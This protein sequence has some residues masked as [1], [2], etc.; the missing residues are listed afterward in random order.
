MAT[1]D[2]IELVQSSS[3]TDIEIDQKVDK[4]EGPERNPHI[5]GP[6]MRDRGGVSGARMHIAA[7]NPPSCGHPY[8]K[9]ETAPQEKTNPKWTVALN[10]EGRALTLRTVYET[11]SS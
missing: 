7:H 11:I 5:C 8:G 10:P 2:A 6:S 3:V 9:N 4:K 1:L